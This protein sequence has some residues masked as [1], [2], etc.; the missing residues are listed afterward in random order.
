MHRR[1]LGRQFIRSHLD[2]LSDE[3]GMMKCEPFKFQLQP[4][5]T[6]ARQRMYPLSLVKKDALLK[7]IQVLLDNDI[8]EPCKQTDWMSPILLVSKGDGRWRLVV[9]YR[10]VNESIVNEPVA[11]PRPDDI[12]ESIQ[13]TYYM[14]LVDGR[15]FY[16]QRELHPIADQ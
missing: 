11:Y 6:P 15:D 3:V 16:F 13:D 8:I 7:M 5:S 4:G 10:R 12:F 1:N 9:D 2:V 14:F